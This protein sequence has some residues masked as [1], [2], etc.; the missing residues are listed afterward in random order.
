MNESIP[1]R[2]FS[3]IKHAIYI[4][5]DSRTDRRELFESHFKELHDIYPTV[6]T[7]LPVTRFPAIQHARGAIGCSKSHLEC[8][9]LAKENGWDHVLIME[10]DALIKHPELLAE[11]VNLFLEKFQDKWDVVLFA[12]N[13]YA[14]FKVEAPFCFRIN[15]CQTAGCYLVCGH[16]YDTLIRNFEES[17]ALLETDPGAHHLYAV[18]MYWKHLQCVDRWYLIT[19]MCVIQR[20]GYSDIEKRIVDYESQMTALSK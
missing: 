2:T 16:Y 4:N 10:D 3:D 17:N 15:N 1:L 19:P 18:D 5:L 6:Y 14:P 13:N 9:R 11:N 7:F 8:I 12:G 20:S